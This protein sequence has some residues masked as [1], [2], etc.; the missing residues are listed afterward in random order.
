[1]KQ[2]YSEDKY[3]NMFNCSL[4]ESI[5]DILLITINLN[6]YSIHLNITID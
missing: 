1:M 3:G 2:G 4:E 6:L 5:I